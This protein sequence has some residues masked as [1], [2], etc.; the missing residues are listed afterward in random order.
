M[1]N[2]S[3]LPSVGGQSDLGIISDVRLAKSNAW[4]AD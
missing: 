4:R 2:C 1:G 3:N